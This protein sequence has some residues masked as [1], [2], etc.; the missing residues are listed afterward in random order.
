MTSSLALTEETK[1]EISDQDESFEEIPQ[2]NFIEHK[3]TR[4]SQYNGENDINNSETK[5]GTILNI[6]DFVTKIKTE[7]PQFLLNSDMIFFILELCI[8]SSQFNLK[9]DNSSRKFWEEVGKIEQLSPVLKI[10]K[11]ETLRKYWRLLRNIKKPKKIIN[12]MK[13]YNS[14]LNNENIKLLACI[15]IIYDYILFPKK[16]IDFFINKYCGKFLNK[17]KKAK[18]VKEMTSDEQIEEIIQEFEKAFPLK[19]EEEIIEKLYQNSFDVRNTYLVLKD[20]NHFSYLSF[21]EEDDKMILDRN[22]TNKQYRELA[23]KKGHNN[24]IRRKNFLVG[25]SIYKYKK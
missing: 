2:K 8:N 23:L 19:K 11:P 3:R 15:N 1:K 9:G 13:E 14:I 20:E 12:I 17:A 7:N 22:L 16:G 18:N 10:F 6:P 5:I 4:R 21:K 24:I 25:K